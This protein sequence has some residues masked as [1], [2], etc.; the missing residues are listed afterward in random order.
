MP[1]I[2][3]T[4]KC[5]KQVAIK[6]MYCPPSTIRLLISSAARVVV[7]AAAAAAAEVGVRQA[8]HLSHTRTQAGADRRTYE[9]VRDSHVAA[10]HRTGGRSPVVVGEP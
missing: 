2:T 9:A 4:V 7:V 8:A 5:E 3:G 1:T 6:H 10:S